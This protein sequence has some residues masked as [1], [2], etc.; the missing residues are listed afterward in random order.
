MSSIRLFSTICL[1]SG[2]MFGLTSCGG[3]SS[4]D[5][6][7]NPGD[8][9]HRIFV[10]STTY[11]G[12]RGGLVGADITCT[13]VAASAGI[14]GSYRAILSSSTE[15]A[16]TRLVISGE[17]YKVTAGGEVTVATSSTNF[18]NLDL[19]SPINMDE[20]RNL[21]TMAEPWTGTLPGGGSDFTRTC[22]DWTDGTITPNGTT[23]DTDVVTSALWVNA[24]G[25]NCNYFRPL[26]CLEE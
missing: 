14:T 23:G 5:S 11:D 9:R 19:L 12:G 15:G 18:W 1:L 22:A 10:T 24:N 3:G 13:N 8:I 7:G 25:Y 2:I 20:D 4:S 26:Y 6:N 17:V 16:N 21:V